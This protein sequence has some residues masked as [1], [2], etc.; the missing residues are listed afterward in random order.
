MMDDVTQQNAALVEQASPAALALTEHARNLTQ[1]IAGYR[2]ATMR[3]RITRARSCVGTVTRSAP[4]PSRAPSSSPARATERRA[5][6]RPMTG[7]KRSAVIAAT[8][9][10]PA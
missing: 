4:G 6:T 5:P 1:L 9:A 2:V 10:Q 7:R 8:G 3:L